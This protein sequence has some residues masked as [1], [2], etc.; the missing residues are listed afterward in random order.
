MVCEKGVVKYFVN[1]T[2]KHL[3]QS[4]LLIKL[5]ALKTPTEV[6]SEEIRE[7]FKNTYFEE[8][9]RATAFREIQSLSQF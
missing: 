5:Q 9:L 7:I 4:L 1:F 6:F 3:C 8:H 2:G